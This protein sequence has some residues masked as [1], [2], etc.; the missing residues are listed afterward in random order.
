MAEPVEL[1]LPNGVSL[2]K[3]VRD[4]F[5]LED[6]ETIQ[7]GWIEI[8]TDIPG[9]V[10]SAEIQAFDG[11]A[12]TAIPLQPVQNSKFVFSHVVRGYGFSTG[13]AIV[14]SG[15]ETATL[16]LELRNPDSELLGTVG[17]LALAP[18]N[19]LVGLISQ[20]F[21]ESGELSGGTVKV[22]SDAPVTG[23]EL[24]YGDDLRVLSAVPPQRID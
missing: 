1:E 21:P 16:V 18:G 3:S 4:L 24:F 7:S 14:N 17:P 5:G 6:R 20:L 8:T 12:L 13:L 22:L 19:R 11:E 15:S 2:R 23:V 10:G 9:I